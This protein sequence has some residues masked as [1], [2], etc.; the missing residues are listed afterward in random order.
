MVEV[1]QQVGTKSHQCPHER[2]PGVHYLANQFANWAS[3]FTAD[4]AA[5]DWTAVRVGEEAINVDTMLR[6]RLMAP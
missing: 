6:P 4:A 5:A 3:S 1:E 2:E